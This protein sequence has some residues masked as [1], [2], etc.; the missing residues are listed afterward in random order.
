VIADGRDYNTD[1]PIIRT[2][3]S[4]VPIAFQNPQGALVAEDKGLYIAKM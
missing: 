3:I 4:E 2:R 1:I